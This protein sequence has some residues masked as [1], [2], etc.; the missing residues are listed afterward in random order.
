MARKRTSRRVDLERIKLTVAEGLALVNALATGIGT[1]PL[2][3][4]IVAALGP[5]KAATLITERKGVRLTKEEVVEL[6]KAVYPLIPGATTKDKLIWVV[7]TAEP[8]FATQER[9][10]EVIRYVKERI[11]LFA[12]G[13][14]YEPGAGGTAPA[15]TDRPSLDAHPYT[16]SGYGPVNA[17]WKMDDALLV[18]ILTRMQQKNV[19][20][21]VVEAMGNAGEDVLGIPAKM[22]IVKQKYLLVAKTCDRLGLWFNPIDFNDNAG[23]GNYSNG[24]VKLEKRIAPAKEFI[25]WQ[26]QQ[27]YQH[28]TFVTPMAETQTSAGRT[29]QAYAAK[30][31]GAAGFRL[32]TNDGARPQ[33]NASWS[34]EFCYHNVSTTDWPKSNRAYVLS[35]TGTAIRAKRRSKLRQLSGGNLNGPGQ[36]DAL[37]KWLADGIARKQK[38][39]AFYE[40]QYNQYNEAA[41]DALAAPTGAGS[42]TSD[43]PVPA[44]AILPSQVRWLGPNFKNAKVTRQMVSASISGNHLN[45][46]LASPLNWPKSG[47]KNVDGIGFLI[48]K[49]GS[50]YVGGKVEWC[51]SSRGW[52]DIRTNVEDGYNGSTMPKSGE[53]VWCGIGHPSNTS[54]CTTLLKVVWP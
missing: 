8:A 49:L 45:F 4:A 39:V 47:S 21:F 16:I 25:E 41:I 19:R 44:G 48:R 26:A 22:A 33:S 18:K 42:G 31:L 14:E 20:V 37:R 51:V 1:V 5:E 54:E 15:V 30:V 2:A 17:W 28:C 35:D 50:E 29:L 53:S 32:C 46:K 36:A 23:N 13:L 27:G 40:F 7:R 3:A 12:A 38:I 10:L 43:V 6:V 9:Y 34:Q 24:G 52:Y 11:K